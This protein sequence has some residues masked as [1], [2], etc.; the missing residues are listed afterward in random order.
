[1]RIGERIVGALD[2][3]QQRELQWQPPLGYLGSDVGQIALRAIENAIEVIRIAHE[4]VTFGVDPRML[5]ALQT[6]AVAQSGKKIVV[7]CS[8]C[9]ERPPW[10]ARARFGIKPGYRA[11]RH[12]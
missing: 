7:A 1:M 4:P 9:R 10:F 3:R 11:G 12:A 2:D 6:K 5:A 8:R